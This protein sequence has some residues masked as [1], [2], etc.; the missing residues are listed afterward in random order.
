M[1][2]RQTTSLTPER[3]S[4]HRKHWPN[5]SPSFGS[6][7]GAQTFTTRRTRILAEPWRRAA[8]QQL[9]QTLGCTISQTS[10]ENGTGT[11]SVLAAI[12]VS[13]ASKRAISLLGSIV[14]KA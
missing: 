3:C 2:V 12:G 4:L 5:P 13:E 7:G 6:M 11:E 14:P 1:F 8:T 10:P 9:P